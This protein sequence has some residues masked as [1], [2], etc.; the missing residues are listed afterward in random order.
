[1]TLDLERRQL[2]ESLHHHS[3]W[4]I[5]FL[6]GP[7]LVCFHNF[8]LSPYLIAVFSPPSS[9][10][11]VL[12]C[13]IHSLNV[14]MVCL[15]WGKTYKV[16]EVEST[17][18]LRVIT[19]Q[20]QCLRHV[21]RCSG[22]VAGS[23]PWSPALLLR[24]ALFCISLYTLVVPVPELCTCSWVHHILCCL[25]PLPSSCTMPVRFVLAVVCRSSSFTSY[26]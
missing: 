20:V 25:L 9:Q 3:W 24:G 1:M 16:H 11:T 12:T 22:A 21:V 23:T 17:V 7:F 14:H 15:N 13:I 19:T 5:W 4:C 6:Q 26:C 8:F 10:T 2:S 18:N